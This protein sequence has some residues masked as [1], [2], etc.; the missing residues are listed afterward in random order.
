MTDD[1][2]RDLAN[3]AVDCD[4]WEWLPG[5][6]TLPCQGQRLWHLDH[7]FHLASG[8]M[9]EDTCGA[10]PDFSDP[11]T[12]GCLL[13]LVRRA[14]DAPT[15]HLCR[16]EPYAT[17]PESVIGVAGGWYIDGVHS[18]TTEAGVLVSALELAGES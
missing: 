6:R 17:G 4:A 9:T 18:A 11:A 8:K 3:R 2:K 14:Y 7:G 16:I 13:E 12:L 10:L 5:M 15:L 1:E